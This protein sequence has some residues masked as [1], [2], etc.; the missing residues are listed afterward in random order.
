[1]KNVV[2]RVLL[3]SVAVPALYAMAWFGDFLYRLPLALVVVAFAGA[4]GAEL[5]RLLEPKAAGLRITVGAAL[6][7]APSIAAYLAQYAGGAGLSSWAISSLASTLALFLAGGLPRAFARAKAEIRDGKLNSSSDALLLI[8]PGLLASTLIPIIGSPG[9]GG[10]LA[11]W[12]SMI[13]FANDS[14]AWLVG[15]TLGRR[16]GIFGVSPNKSLEGLLAGLIGSVLGAVLGPVLM[17]LLVPAVSSATRLPVLVAFGL[18][19]GAFVV[20]GDLYESSL[21]RSA[22]IKDSGE[23][24]PGRGGF[25]DSFDSILYAAPIFL[26]AMAVFGIL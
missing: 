6:A 4:G 12:F 26:A 20:A 17:P 2:A 22:E 23:A 11:I 14:L 10:M 1:M 7:A 3:V 24:I 15:I 25:L 5:M 21:K 19:S 9:K 16:R 8:Y 13:V 18:V